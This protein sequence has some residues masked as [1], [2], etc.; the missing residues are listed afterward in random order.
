VSTGGSGGTGV[1]D[2]PQQIPCSSPAGTTCFSLVVN[3]V[4]RT[5]ALHVPSNFQK[6]TGT[7]IIALHGGGGTGLGMESLTGFST[8]AD[9]DGFAVAYP[10]GQVDASEGVQDWAYFF[11]DFT[12]DVTFFRQLITTLQATVAPDPK[13]IFVAGFSAGGFM[14]HRLGVE[15][16]DLIAGIG[17]VEGAL[18]SSEDLT[19]VPSALGPV[20][21][22]ILQ[23]DEDHTVPYC[24]DTT[25]ASQEETFNYWSGTSANSCSTFDTSL[26]LCDSSGNITTVSEKDATGCSGNTEVKFYKLIGGTHAWNTGPMNVAGQTPYNPDFDSNTGITTR[27]IFWNFFSTHPKQ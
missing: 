19:A 10:D 17:V 1:T 14:S 7:L 8:L 23:G 18:A 20:S 9:Q 6:N 21:V 3:G 11:N 22:V 25:D 15:V 27:D 24:G 2:D 5:Y 26:A 13:R 4:T 16:S 12:D